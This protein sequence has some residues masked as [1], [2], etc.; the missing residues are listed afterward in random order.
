MSDYDDSLLSLGL[1]RATLNGLRS[2]GFHSISD[3]RGLTEVEILRL[4]NVN[5]LALNKILCARAQSMP[6][7]TGV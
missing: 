2:A 5:L 3:F 7:Q 4:P 6:A 1:R